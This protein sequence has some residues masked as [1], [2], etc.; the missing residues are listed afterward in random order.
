MKLLGFQ[1]NPYPYLCQA[2]LF[3]SC[4]LS[5]S[6][7]LAVQ[8]A[9]VLNVP[10]AAVR[11]SGIEESLDPRFGVLMENSF[12]DAKAVLEELLDDPEKLKN[13]RENIEKD[14]PVRDLYE[15]RLESI[16]EMW[17]QQ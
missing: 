6:Y 16:F 8:E 3:V 13:Y 12:D 17:E 15:K 2:D 14:F 7:G 4:S 11:C 5:E 9:L 10:V 1:A